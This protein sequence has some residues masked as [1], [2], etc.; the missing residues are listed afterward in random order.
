[1]IT[2]AAKKTKVRMK[3]GEEAHLLL[4]RFGSLLH[5]FLHNLG[6]LYKES[7]NNAELNG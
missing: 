1:M 3:A 2:S 7:P 6:F 4:A 5:H